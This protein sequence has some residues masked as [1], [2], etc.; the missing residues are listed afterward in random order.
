MERLTKWE[1]HNSDGTPR[2]VMAKRDGFFPDNMQEV[3]VKLAR[4]EDREEAD[5]MGEIA[6]IENEIYINKEIANKSYIFVQKE[7]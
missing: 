5:L 1:G 7:E 4:Y 6:K 3:L 2:A